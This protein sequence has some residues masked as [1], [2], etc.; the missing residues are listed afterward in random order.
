MKVHL[1]I[2][3]DTKCNV[4]RDAGNNVIGL[5]FEP[6]FTTERGQAILVYGKAVSTGGKMLDRFALTVSGTTGK[7][8]KKN[9]MTTVQPA[10]DD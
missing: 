6:A 5:E 3:P 10:V 2:S 1:E 7:V 8:A 9:R 4:L